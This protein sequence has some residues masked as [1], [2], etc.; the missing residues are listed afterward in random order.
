MLTDS[1]TGTT[2]LRQD[3]RVW[4]THY[5]S[6]VPNIRQRCPSCSSDIFSGKYLRIWFSITSVDRLCISASGSLLGD[7]FQRAPLRL[8]TMGGSSPA[9]SYSAS[10]V[11]NP[12]L[13]QASFAHFCR[14]SFLR[15]SHLLPFQVVHQERAQPANVDILLRQS[16]LRRFR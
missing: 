1:S 4:K 5:I 16:D 10:W 9:D 6:T 7:L 15:R 12:N 13:D 2:M 11:R 3:S 8:S 14:I